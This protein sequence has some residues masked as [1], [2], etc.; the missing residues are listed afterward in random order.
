MKEGKKV[1]T[2]RLWEEVLLAV[3]SKTKE[4]QICYIHTV[5]HVWI[6]CFCSDWEIRFS[7]FV[8]KGGKT[9]KNVLCRKVCAWNSTSCSKNGIENINTAITL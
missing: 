1:T 5:I 3:K 8:R 2:D 7:Y 9:A 6:F 4:S